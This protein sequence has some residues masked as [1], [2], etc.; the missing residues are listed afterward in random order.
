ML[1]IFIEI[2]SNAIDNVERSRKTKTPV[3]KIS[4]KIDSETG[5]TS[6]WNDGQ[7]IPIEKN[8]DGKYFHSMVFGEL[9]T[10]SNYDDEE[11]RVI[12]GRNGLGCK[13]TSIFSSEFTVIYTQE[14][15]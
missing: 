15:N 10:G 3:T 1:R 2:L 6:V 12:S 14:V 11:E 5:E 4:V 8:D 9:L 13:L 7:V